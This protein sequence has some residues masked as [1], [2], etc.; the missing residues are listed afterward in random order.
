MLATTLPASRLTQ[1]HHAR[2]HRA[3]HPS[4]GPTNT[5]PHCLWGASAHQ[6]A[7]QHFT[8]LVSLIEV[9]K[10]LSCPFQLL[11]LSQRRLLCNSENQQLLLV[12]KTCSKQRI[13]AEPTVLAVT[14][15]T[16]QMHHNRTNPPHCIAGLMLH[17]ACHLTHQSR[18]QHCSPYYC[19]PK[20]CQLTRPL[21]PYHPNPN[22]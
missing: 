19:L 9:R 12:L 13:Q 18:D 17:H 15:L 4:L 6:A 10:S 14:L 21:P 5:A 11:T 20:C 22:L 16:M 2:T 7:D 8:S 3:A 1:T